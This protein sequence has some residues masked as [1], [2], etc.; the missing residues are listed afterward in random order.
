M[1]FRHGPSP[2]A[3]RR[4][5]VTRP[6]DNAMRLQALKTQIDSATYAVDPLEVAEALLSYAERHTLQAGPA[7]DLSDAR[8]G[9]RTRR[10]RPRSPRD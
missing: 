7:D 3:R 6:D 10:G 4:Y 9:A 2:N 8:P 1:K 5:A